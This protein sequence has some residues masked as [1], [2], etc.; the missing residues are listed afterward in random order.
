MSLR[1]G[2][3]LG[4]ILEI[5]LGPIFTIIAVGWKQGND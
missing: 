5:R 2:R 3:L 1:E 4:C